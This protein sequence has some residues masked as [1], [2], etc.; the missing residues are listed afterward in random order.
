MR[1]F[2]MDMKVA[3][4]D[5]TNFT[6][7]IKTEELIKTM[8][9]ESRLGVNYESYKNNPNGSV[10]N[11]VEYYTYEQPV[12]ISSKDVEK[13]KDLSTSYQELTEKGVN[14]S[15]YEEPQYHYSKLADLKVKLLQSATDDAK[16]LFDVNFF[17]ALNIVKAVLP[18]MREAQHGRILFT[19]SVAAP[20]S[21]PYQSF[22]SASKAALN[23]LALALQNEIRP[24]GIRVGV[25]MPGDV[26]T[27]FTDARQKN[28]SE[29][30]KQVYPRTEKAVAAMEKDERNGMQPEQ[31]ARLFYRMATRRF[32]PVYTIGGG[33]YQ[34][35]CLLDRLL[36]KTLVNKI[37]GAMY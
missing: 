31:M 30:E 29:L 21:V 18:Y 32:L 14:I 4:T 12:K 36:P 16:A 26:R 17:G 20:L 23:A 25:L 27:G 6:H 19:S 5:N 35:F 33:L 15:S 37:E 24:Y 9:G 22:Y 13:I 1:G 10:S 7:L 3:K 8:T 34:L 11:I 28:V 2:N